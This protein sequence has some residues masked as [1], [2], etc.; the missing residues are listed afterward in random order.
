MVVLDAADAAVWRIG[1]GLV[2]C[3]VR[4]GRERMDEGLEEGSEGFPVGFW[5]GTATVGLGCDSAA[6]AD[7][8]FIVEGPLEGTAF[9]IGGS[10]GFG[11]VESSAMVF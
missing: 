8:E 9:F 7:F 11:L 6:A 4:L 2:G 1:E 10:F 5:T 3:G